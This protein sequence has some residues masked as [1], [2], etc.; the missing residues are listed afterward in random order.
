MRCAIC[1]KR[2]PAHTVNTAFCAYCGARL[3]PPPSPLP[4]VDLDVAT[5]QRVL[6][7][8]VLGVPAGLAFWLVVSVPARWTLGQIALVGGLVGALGGLAGGLLHARL[9]WPLRYRPALLRGSAQLPVL[10]GV[11]GGLALVA[12]GAPIGLVVLLLGWGVLMPS[13]EALIAGAFAGAISLRVA[14]PLAVLAGAATGWLVG[15]FSRR[16][17]GTLG[18]ALAAG[19]AWVNAGAVGGALIGLV[20]ANR[21]ELDPG[22]GAFTGALIQIVLGAL[23][24]P[25]GVRAARGLV[26]FWFNRP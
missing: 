6:T 22:R 9:F 10:Y 15:R 11:G 20:V 25:L 4:P 26:I 1:R 19:L 17:R 5:W 16:L 7:A 14:V 8:L 18:L 24:L 2:L 12:G 3:P 23:L 21:V 13:M